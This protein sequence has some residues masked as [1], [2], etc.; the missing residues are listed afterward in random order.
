MNRRVANKRRDQHYKLAWKLCREYDVMCLEDNDY[1]EMRISKRIVNGHRV[2]KAQRGRLWLWSPAS[3]LE[4]LKEVAAKTGKTVF[5]ANRFFASSQ[6]CNC[7][8]YRNPKLKDQKIRKWKC[9]KCGEIHD[10]DI[11][12]AKNL[13]KEYR[14]TAGEASSV[15]AQKGAE[16]ER[17]SYWN[18]IRK[19]ASLKRAAGAGEKSPCPQGHGSTQIRKE[20]EVV[21]V[22][23]ELYTDAYTVQTA[24]EG[25]SNEKSDTKIP[26]EKMTG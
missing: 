4:I 22:C 3:F 10:R 12:A 24:R 6:I 1:A 13:V 21:A 5:L 8:G 17:D 11:N 20:G 23:R 18:R 25:E 9:P 16:T 2:N 7:C 19:S 15:A 14:R 26:E